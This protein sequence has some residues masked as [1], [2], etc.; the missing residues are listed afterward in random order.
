MTDETAPVSISERDLR[1]L[2][3]K[4]NAQ[5][6]I[7]RILIHAIVETSDDPDEMF[8]RL[9]SLTMEEGDILQSP[10][11]SSDANF[12]EKGRLETLQFVSDTFDAVKA[13]RS[14]LED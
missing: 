7:V 8:E 1:R 12:V 13:G 2:Y 6:V 10:S 4:L 11:T 9:R 14:D 5:E 3:A